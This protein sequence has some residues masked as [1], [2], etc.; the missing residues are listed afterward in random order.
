MSWLSSTIDAGMVVNPARVR[1]AELLGTIGLS[2]VHKLVYL[3]I[4]RYGQSGLDWPR[5]ERFAAKGIHFLE[6]STPR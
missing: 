2:K 4:G 3:Y 5:L 6:P 1:R